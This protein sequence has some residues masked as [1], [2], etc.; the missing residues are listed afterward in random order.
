MVFS[1][2][3]DFTCMIVPRSIHEAADDTVSLFSAAE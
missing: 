2:R 3:S 1:F